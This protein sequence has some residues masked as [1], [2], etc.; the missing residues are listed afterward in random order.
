MQ[1]NSSLVEHG[2]NT[3]DFPVFE[4]DDDMLEEMFSIREGAG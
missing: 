3:D 1:E 2:E 4:V